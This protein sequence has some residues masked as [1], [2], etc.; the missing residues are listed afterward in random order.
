M[1]QSASVMIHPPVETAE[2]SMTAE[3]RP[4]E[5][6]EPSTSGSGRSLPEGGEGG[7]ST[8]MAGGSTARRKRGGR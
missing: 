4:R 1:K 5:R 6:E 3:V 8:E 2:T 7:G